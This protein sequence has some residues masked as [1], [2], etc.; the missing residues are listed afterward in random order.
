MDLPESER[1]HIDL[2]RE[3]EHVLGAAAQRTPTLA[4]LARQTVAI[5]TYAALMADTLPGDGDKHYSNILLARTEHAVRQRYTALT[6]RGMPH[7]P[8]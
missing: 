6:Q 5:L 3:H 7:G 8:R 1:Q 2:M 4:N